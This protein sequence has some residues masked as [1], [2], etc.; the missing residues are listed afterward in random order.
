[1]SAR[2]FV[3]SLLI[4]A[5]AGA[6]VM[7]GPPMF[8]HAPG[9]PLGVGPGPSSLAISDIN[10]DGTPDLVVTGR[11]RRVTILL[12]QGDGRFSS[13]RDGTFDVPENPSEL[14]LGDVNGD[15]RVDLALASHEGYNVVLLL[16]DGRGRWASPAGG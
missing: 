2:M 1:M 13:N 7:A 11:G 12:G 9:S 4:A 16:G 3:L 6:M 8:V 15:G 5:A 10:G 14:A